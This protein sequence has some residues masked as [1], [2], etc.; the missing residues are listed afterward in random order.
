MSPFENWQVALLI[1]NMIAIIAG[2]IVAIRITRR[3]DEEKEKHQRKF[4]I[5][6]NLMKTRQILL[7]PVH[8]AAINLVPLEF[9]GEKEILKPHTDYLKHLASAMPQELERERYFKERRTLFLEMMQEMGKFLKYEFDKH[10][11]DHFGYV[12][13][14]WET[15]QQLQ[16][17]NATLLSEVLSGQRPIPIAPHAAGQFPPPPQ[18][19]GAP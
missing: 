11:L 6:S 3:L 2:P 16:R 17:R 13:V 8:V 4:A 5:F 12:P 19:E 10:E 18:V 15:D 14:G 1:V 9:Y 7:D